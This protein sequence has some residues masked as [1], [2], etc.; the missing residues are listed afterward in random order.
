[1]GTFDISNV[2]DRFTTPSLRLDAD[3]MRVLIERGGYVHPLFVDP[4][5]AAAS[6]L[7]RTPLPGPAV[8]LLIG[9]LAEQSGRFD[10]TVI[11]LV[12]FDEVRFLAPA[13]EGDLVH[14]DVE[15]LEREDRSG[16][17]GLLTMRWRMLR[18]DGAVLC[19]ARARM[20]FAREG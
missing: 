19:D 18:D 6:E 13:F 14:A 3:L 1:M 8:L 9:G 12:G 20:L 11:A 5:Y 10:G 7:G 16:R 2:G 4:E 15:V 17:R